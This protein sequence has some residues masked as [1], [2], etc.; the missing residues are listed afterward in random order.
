MKFQ[1][2]GFVLGSLIAVIGLAELIPALLDYSMGHTNADVFAL[3]AIL[4][5]FL[6]FNLAFANRGFEKCLSLR[7]AF[8]LTTVSWLTIALFAALPLYMSDLKI[9]FVDAYFEAMSGFTT[10]GSTVLSGLDQASRGVLLWRSMIEWIGGMGIIAFAIIF[11]PFLQIGGMQLFQTESSDKSDKIM[12]RSGTVILA[13][14]TVYCILTV[15]CAATYFL[16]GMN[17]FDA[18]NH[19]MTTISTAGFSTHDR[20][21]GYFSNP[22]ILYAAS[23]FMFLSALPF[24][25]FVSLI[26][27]KQWAFAQ[28]EQVKTLGLI[29]LTIVSIMTL[30][31]WH[32]SDYSFE[33]SFRHALFNLMSV[34]STTGYAST[35]YMKWGSFA[36][37]A[38]LFATYIGGCAG[39]TAGGPKTMRLIIAGKVVNRQFKRLLNPH[40]IFAL[41]YQGKPLEHP[42]VM[43]TL[44]FLSLYVAV[45]VIIALAVTLTGV[46]FLTAVSGVAT[47]MANAGCGVGDIIGPAG[48]FAALPDAAKWLLALAMMLG[49]LE[50]LTVFVLFSKE[51]WQD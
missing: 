14:F 42:V 3:N 30:W 47:A 34:I 2:A 5:L 28:D 26:I 24:V 39:S 45:N 29:V 16:L 38:F 46:D 48:N 20:S 21:F 35:D 36:S 18:I 37:V 22:L 51:Y 8:F 9:S 4:C 32:N 1:I 10:T 7:E 50:I 15:S 19:A 43:A 25:L 27:K 41:Q 49:R 33:R 6:G 17:A 44:G 12:P 23:L 13:L 40:G 31:L 11:L